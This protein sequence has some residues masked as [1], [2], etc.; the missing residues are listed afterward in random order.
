MAV[1]MKI[2]SSRRTAPS[3]FVA[4]VML[5][6]MF[7]ISACGGSVSTV[8]NLQEGAKG[9]RTINTKVGSADI[10]SD[11]TG[12]LAAIE[13]S[14]RK[15][16][17]AELSYGGA[18]K[19]EADAVQM[20]FVLAFD[21]EEDYR[22]K[23]KALLA[24][25]DFDKE[26]EVT[27]GIEDSQFVSGFAMKENFTSI[28]LMGW[29]G[30]ALVKDKVI[31]AGNQSKVFSTSGDSQI[32][33]GGKKYTSSDRLAATEVTDK[34]FGKIEVLTTVNQD[35]SYSQKITYLLAEGRRAKLGADLDAFFA[36]ATPDGGV[37][38]ETFDTGTFT[39]GWTL[40][41]TAATVE[42]LSA[43]TNQALGS[44]KNSY[45]FEEAAAPSNP[46]LLR[47]TLSGRMDCSSICSPSGQSLEQ[48]F[49]VPEN[50]S[51]VSGPSGAGPSTD[52]GVTV[53][54]QDYRLVYERAIPLQSMA[55]NTV[56]GLNGK[57]TSTFDFVASAE[58]I[59]FV[60][61]AFEERLAPDAGTGS[62]TVGAMGEATTYQVVIEADSIEAYNDKMQSYVPGA[63]LERVEDK[64][65]GIWPK[66]TILQHLPLNT[67]LASSGVT[68][69]VQSSI[70][71]PALH[72]FLEAGSLPPNQQINAGKLITT[73]LEDAGEVSV[74]MSGP[75]LGGFIFLCV[76]L[77]LVVLAVVFALVFRRR[78]A[79]WC[80]T[81][82]GQR[83][84]AGTAASKLA[85]TVARSNAA[86]G[87]AGSVTASAATLQA[88]TASANDSLRSSSHT[89]RF[90]E[91]DLR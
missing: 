21:S 7:M 75:T 49:V 33:Y 14:I 57:V 53:Q 78:I 71:L 58:S 19:G 54:G 63:M 25:G 22:N 18:K 43:G 13:S 36:T 37:L 40:T 38:D 55:V 73:G 52:G 76:L 56:L 86:A 31:E 48:T 84:A 91:A 67:S 66:S 2:H 29:L 64:G 77:V 90:V 81:A 88:G 44:E 10:E 17:P 60:G 34:G 6:L 83:T 68:E 23:V 80:R 5:A 1:K 8:F 20:A 39:D 61:K 9:T 35:E 16:L 4:A 3:A 26:P 59:G 62:F 30:K 45:I 65:M 11:V 32:V 41:F 12:G 51:Y 74:K 27:L 46:T 28:D 42:E 79:S 87:L 47:S 89:D 24:A 85:S 15:N 82:W 50:W 72:R 70:E 69:T